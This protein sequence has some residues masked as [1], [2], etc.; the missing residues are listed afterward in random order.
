MMSSS[1][2]FLSPNCQNQGPV[3]FE[4]FNSR[5]SDGSLSY[6]INSIPAKVLVPIVL[7][8]IEQMHF[9]ARPRVNRDLP[10]LFSPRT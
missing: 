5:S 6:E 8:R 9:F 2:H 3:H 7:P 1:F 10:G 4:S